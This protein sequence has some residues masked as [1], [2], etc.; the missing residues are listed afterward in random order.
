MK[1]LK[2]FRIKKIIKNDVTAEKEFVRSS[3][4]SNG[5]KGFR[6]DLFEEEVKYS[7]LLRIMKYLR[8]IQRITPINKYYCYN[9]YANGKNAYFCF[10]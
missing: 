4:V 8:I 6:N 7:P 9:S 3:K 2:E 5:L 1:I 10:Y